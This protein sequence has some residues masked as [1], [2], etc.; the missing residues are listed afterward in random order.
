MGTTKAIGTTNN[1]VRGLAIFLLA[2]SLPGCAGPAQPK[3][4]VSPADHLVDGQSVTIRL[5]GFGFDTKVWVSECAGAGA[6]QSRG[7]GAELPAQTPVVIGM[8]GAGVG[9]F[10]VTGKAQAGPFNSAQIE[11]CTDLCV[12]VAT[13]GQDQAYAS[14]PIL[15]DTP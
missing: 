1:L 13:L 9:T 8:D 10:T 4:T 15:F 11:A 2:V 3:V 14:Q 6:A 7:C 12:V 5:S